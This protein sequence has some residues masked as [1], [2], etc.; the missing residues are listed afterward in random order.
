[1]NSNH[2]TSMNHI[3]LVF[4]KESKSMGFIY[5]FSS[6]VRKLE[7]NLIHLIRVD[8]Q[9]WTKLCKTIYLISNPKDSVFTWYHSSLSVVP[10]SPLYCHLHSVYLMFS[11]SPS[12]L[13]SVWSWCYMVIL[14]LRS[15]C[16]TSMFFSC[17]HVLFLLSC[18]SLSL[19]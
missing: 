13:C 6:S 14:F 8:C 9:L 10:H 7:V 11:S 1:M 3:Y 17:C 18:S 19:A 16:L 2:F 15:Y 12:T 5:I 4:F